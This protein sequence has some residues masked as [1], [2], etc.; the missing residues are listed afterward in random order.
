MRTITLSE[1]AE[2]T[3]YE[4]TRVR[5]ETNAG[6]YFFT[7]SALRRIG[8]PF[9]REA[10]EVGVV[11]LIVTGDV[12]WAPWGCVAEHGQVYLAEF[13]QTGMSRWRATSGTVVF[14]GMKI[15]GVHLYM[16]VTL[17]CLDQPGKSMCLKGHIDF[18]D[19]FFLLY[20]PRGPMKWAI[21]QEL[22]KGRPHL[23]PRP[24]G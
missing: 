19:S 17:E 10:P 16:D 14:E 2:R 15:R 22:S 7:A 4:M 9:S 12:P 8:S 13:H 18:E 3:Y 11:V 21:E 5:S 1:G 24:P 6:K 20:A 23:L